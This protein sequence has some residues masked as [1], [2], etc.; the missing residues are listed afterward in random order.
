MVKSAW[1]WM[2]MVFAI[3]AVGV[4]GFLIGQ[5]V[6]ASQYQANGLPA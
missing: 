6:A 3:V 4:A 1:K 2:A 5:H